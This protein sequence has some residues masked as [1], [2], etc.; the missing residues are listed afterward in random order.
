MEKFDVL[1]IGSGHNALIT[2]AYLAKAGR[3]VL[4]LEKN[5]RPGGL[6][7]TEELTLPGFQHD[8]YASA[9]P[10]FVTGPAYADLGAELAERGLRYLNTD[11]PTGVSL[12]NGRTAVLSRSLEASI[13]EADRLA[14][15]DGAALA[16]LVESFYPYAGDVFSLFS[17]DLA[18]PAA[19]ET[20]RRLLH[21]DN[22]PAYA[23]FAKQLFETARTVVSRFRS[24]EMQALLA[25]W[26]MHLGRTPDE[27]GSGIWVTLVVLALMGG[28]MAIP[29]GGSERLVQSLARLITDNGGQIR[30]GTGVDRVLVKDG[31]AVGVRTATGEEIAASVAVVASV[32]SDQL[33][34]ELLKETEVPA[35]LLQ[36]AKDFR[37]GRG[38][39][40]IHLAL[41][42]PPRWPDA[43]FHQVGQPHL[44]GGL[45]SCTLAIAQAMNGLLPEEPAFTVDCPT[46]F[47]PGRAPAGKAVLRVQFLEIPCR[48]RGDAAGRIKTGDGRWT[49]ELTKRFTDRA[50][51]LLKKHIPGIDSSIR[52][53]RVITPDHLAAFNPNLGP[54]DPYSGAHDL[55][56]S[57]VLRPLPGQPGH[58][59]FVPNLYQTGAGTWPGHGVNGGSGYIV[60]Q[61]LLS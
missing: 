42:E 50:L 7:R 10:L 61:Q 51:H 30:T 39:V 37:Y 56:Q 52:A 26:V 36:Q 29:E 23:P 57:Y 46:N 19:R 58:R 6:V 33:Y 16:Q 13:A 47:D 3:S 22:G 2:A 43:R 35:H 41:D 32:N 45:E 48:P 53:H 24:P 49:E 15:G 5:D 18:T 20:I 38:C 60:A 31:R 9:H 14:A 44:T 25:P 28:G 17:Q 4:V 34:R 40:Q 21:G 54:G 55:A 59:T 11:L 12:G 1:L 8:V 27:V